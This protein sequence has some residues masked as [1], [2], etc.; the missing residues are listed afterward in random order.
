MLRVGLIV[1]I[2]VQ[3]II[4]INSD[5]LLR[6]LMELSA[7]VSTLVLVRNIKLASR[8]KSVHQAREH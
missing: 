6:S 7:F 4:A 5:G 1:A 3:I 8:S 2:I